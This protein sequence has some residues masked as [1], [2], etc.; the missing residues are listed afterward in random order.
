MSAYT[1]HD[2]DNIDEEEQWAIINIER[3][4]IIDK[5]CSEISH[6]YGNTGELQHN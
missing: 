6:T 1:N 3:S 5:D 2:K 4:L